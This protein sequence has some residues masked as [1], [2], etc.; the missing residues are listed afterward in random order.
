MND[1]DKPLPPERQLDALRDAPVSVDLD[2][3][4]PVPPRWWS[5]PPRGSWE[6][7]YELSLL[8]LQAVKDRPE[9]WAQR[10]AQ[11]VDVEFVM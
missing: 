9:V 6:A 11:R 3:E 4:F 1:S 2:L 5:D 7:G 8:A 10:D